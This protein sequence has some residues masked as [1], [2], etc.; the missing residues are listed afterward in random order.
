M[1]ATIEFWFDFSSPY[2]YFAS[3]DIER[4]LARFQ[5]VILWRPY[6]IH[7]GPSEHG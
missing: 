3:L 2:G 6:L 5:N 1:P 7:P 4:R